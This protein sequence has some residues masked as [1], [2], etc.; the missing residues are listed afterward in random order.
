MGF[1]LAD[2]FTRLG[3]VEL[4]GI[5]KLREV[6]AVGVQILDGVFGGDE[7]DDGFA[8]FVRCADVDDVDARRGGGEG[9]VC[10]AWAESNWMKGANRNR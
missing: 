5:C 9:L 2:D 6:A 3:F 10:P 4:A 8:A 1:A 7:D